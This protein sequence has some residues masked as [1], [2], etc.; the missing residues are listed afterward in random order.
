MQI[1]AGILKK[2]L[3]SMT[4]PLPLSYGFQILPTAMLLNLFVK[5]LAF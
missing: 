5:K 3:A 2:T 4:T 1:L